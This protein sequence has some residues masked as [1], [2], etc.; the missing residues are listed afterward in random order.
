MIT[1]TQPSEHIYFTPPQLMAALDRLGAA[2]E[3][4]CEAA[5]SAVMGNPPF[6]PAP[7]VPN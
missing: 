3:P 5:W 4:V 1:S 7:R 2:G 6:G